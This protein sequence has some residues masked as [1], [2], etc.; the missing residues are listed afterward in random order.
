MSN[1]IYALIVIYNKNVEDSASY[2]ELKLHNNINVIVCDNSTDGM[3]NLRS[4]HNDG[5]I[6]ISM[7]GNKGL[8]C[9]YNT[10]LEYLKDMNGWFCIFDDDT[11]IPKDYFIKL[12]ETINFSDAD[13]IVPIVRS[14]NGIMSPV[15]LENY[16]ISKVEN[17][18]SLNDNNIAAINSGIAIKL[19]FLSGYH[20]DEKLFLDFVDYNFFLDMRSRN[21][22]IKILDCELNQEFSTESG[23]KKSQKARLKIKKKDLKYFY[24]KSFKTKAYYF[25]LILRLKIKL[26]LK[27]KDIRILGW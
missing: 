26:L 20:Y 24:S 21:A 15:C 2:K 9:A 25:Y 16:K 12:N 27:F 10:T 23:S 19:E 22:K 11:C 3:D 8:S 1:S 17:I 4:V 5:N 14:K 6:Y 13:I 18:H 7:N